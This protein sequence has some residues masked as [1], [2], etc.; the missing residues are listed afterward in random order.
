[1]VEL[2][3]QCHGFLSA[4]LRMK[5]YTKLKTVNIMAECLNLKLH[6]RLNYFFLDWCIVMAHELLIRLFLS[7]GSQ[8]RRKC[9]ITQKV[10]KI[11]P[12]SLNCV[13]ENSWY[14]DVY[15]SNGSLDATYATENSE[16]FHA[17]K[18]YP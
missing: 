1:M 10:I 15:G 18:K 17:L 5:L 12:L 14:V 7:C 6:S 8:R 2:A 16:E 11:R 3:A 9:R 13:S 4:C